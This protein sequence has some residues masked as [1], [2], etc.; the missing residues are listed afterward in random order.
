M[1]K[2]FL[3]F[4]IILLSYFHLFVVVVIIWNYAL[5][6]LNFIAFYVIKYI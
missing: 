3:Y 4:I 6:V 1:H 2:M 5:Y